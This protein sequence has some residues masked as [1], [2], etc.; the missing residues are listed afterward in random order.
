M[1]SELQR[2][3][4]YKT[5]VTVLCDTSMPMV[6]PLE[7]VVTSA[8]P[9]MPITTTIHPL[10]LELP[11]RSHPDRLIHFWLAPRIS[12][13][14]RLRCSRSFDNSYFNIMSLWCKTNLWETFN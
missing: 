6:Q 2:C 14:Q 9:V 12:K 11:M 8:F 7:V 1:K 10:I 4:Y 13:Y 3:A 5:S